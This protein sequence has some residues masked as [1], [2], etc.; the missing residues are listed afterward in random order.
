MKRRVYL[1][2]V[3]A[4][5][6]FRTVLAAYGVREDAE[7][8]VQRATRHEFDDTGYPAMSAAE[9]LGIDNVWVE[10]LAVRERDAS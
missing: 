7:R 3:C 2:W 10:E 5:D 1:V 9:M 6:G 4:N 8:H